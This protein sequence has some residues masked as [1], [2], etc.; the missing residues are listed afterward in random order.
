M[1]QSDGT[2]DDQNY[3]HDRC[4]RHD[5]QCLLAGFMEALNV[6]PPEIKGYKNSK[7]RGEKVVRKPSHGMARLVPNIVNETR[8]VLSS[9]NRA[10]RTGKNVVEQQRGNRELGKLRAH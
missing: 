8:E 10:Q 7:A 1:P 5:L 3:D 4:H 6:F 9:N 2:P